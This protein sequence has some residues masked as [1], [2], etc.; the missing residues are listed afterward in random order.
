MNDDDEAGEV[1]HHCGD[2]DIYIT[3]YRHTYVMQPPVTQAVKEAVIQDWVRGMRRD[4][5]AAKHDLSAGT[6]TNIVQK[7]E[8]DLGKAVAEADGVRLTN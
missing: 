7:W 5:I 4:A 1:S 2:D 6:I 8:L 3:S